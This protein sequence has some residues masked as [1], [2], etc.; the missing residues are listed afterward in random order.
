MK[1]RVPG[2]EPWGTPGVTGDGFE[3]FELYVSA[4]LKN[5]LP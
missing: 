4:I 2:T 3:E 1:R 5:Q